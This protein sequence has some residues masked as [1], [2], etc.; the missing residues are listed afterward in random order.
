[1]LR[2]SSGEVVLRPIVVVVD[3]NRTESIVLLGLI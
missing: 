3:W 1:L 2:S